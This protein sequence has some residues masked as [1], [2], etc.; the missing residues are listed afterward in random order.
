MGH[1]GVR[2]QLSTGA[3]GVMAVKKTRGVYYFYFAHKTD[4]FAVS[5]MASTED[6]P[7]LVMSRLTDGA[8]MARGGR[9]IRI[10]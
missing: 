5:S 9:K 10:D 2:S 8:P 7:L 6:H 1:P 3:I 4:S